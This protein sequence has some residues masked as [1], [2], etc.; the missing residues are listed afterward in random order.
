MSRYRFELAGEADD[1]T[2]R[3]IMATTPMPGDVALTFRREPSY[4][5]AAVVEGDFRQ[6][7]AAR[8]LSSGEIVG[9]GSRAVSPC[10]VNG[11]P[12]PV[13]YLSSLRLSAEHRSRGLVARGY[14]YFRELHADGRAPFYLTTIAADNTAALALLTSGRAGL[15]HYRPLGDYVT[16]ALPLGKHR[17][18]RPPP[19]G[20]EIRH[21]V[22]ADLPAILEL[23][24]R[25]ARRRQFFP[26]YEARHFSGTPGRLQGLSVADVMLALRRDRPIGMLAGW[27]QGAFRQTVVQTLSPRLRL[28]RPWFNAWQTLVGGPRLPPPG[29]RLPYLTAALPVVDDDD[30]EVFAS[31]VAAVARRKRGGSHECLLLGLHERDPLWRAIDRGRMTT[32]RTKLF[33]VS[34]DEAANAA[35][36]DPRPPY[37]ELGCL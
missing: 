20:V 2:L 18:R 37:L 14:A 19:V 3:R 11:E 34:W 23:L 13:G 1:A 21:A 29:G 17:P 6:V 4:F 7:A 10:F 35:A 12:M 22:A 9:F 15:P 32:Y 36:G 33:G 5:A 28:V 25:H 27:D 24:Q 31:L 30:A 8:D 16:L 26:A